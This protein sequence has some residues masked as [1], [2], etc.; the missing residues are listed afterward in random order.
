[1]LL[2]I[3]DFINSQPLL[4]PLRKRTLELCTDS[5]ARLAD[6]LSGGKLDMAMIPA[7]EYLKQADRFR[8]LPNISISSRKQVGTVLLVSKVPLNAVRSLALDER[9]RTSVA[10]LNVLYSKVFPS[11]LK[12]ESQKPDPEKMLKNHDAALVIGDQALGFSKEGVSVYD[13]SEEWFK[14]T[15]KT[16]VHAVIAVREGVPVENEIIQTLLE[17]KQEGLESLDVIAETQ[18]NK[19]GHP[20]TLLQDYLKNKI[21]YDFGKEEVEGLLHFQSLCHESGLIREKF[22]FRFV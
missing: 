5:P 20:V 2:G 21:R 19:T 15:G 4:E 11:V 14:R 13:L 1:M 22:P 17:A 16:F 10:L 6:Q 12:L 18:A 9:S 8:L 7:I 3:H